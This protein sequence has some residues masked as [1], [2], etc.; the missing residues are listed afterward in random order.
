MSATSP[1][2]GGGGAQVAW[3]WLA[4]CHHRGWARLGRG[5]GAG[6]LGEVRSGGSGLRWLVAAGGRGSRGGGSP[7]PGVLGR[8]VAGG[9][10]GSPSCGAPG[11]LTRIKNVYSM[12]HSSCTYPSSGS[13]F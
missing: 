4:G 12:H 8:V 1:G 7:S 3:I 11:S 10:A 9:S 13:T 5:G 6:K 2:S